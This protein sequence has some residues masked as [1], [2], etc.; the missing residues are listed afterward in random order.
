M[1]T[2]GAIIFNWVSFVFMCAA[3]PF[4][5]TGY[6]DYCYI[7]DYYSTYCSFNGGAWTLAFSIPALILN[8]VSFALNCNLR[9]HE[10]VCR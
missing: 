8:V 4:G 5:I 6:I 9:N 2:I 7:Q 3:V 1:A 10:I